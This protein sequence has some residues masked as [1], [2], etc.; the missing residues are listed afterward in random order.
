MRSAA[1]VALFHRPVGDDLLE[2]GRRYHRFWLELAALGLSAAPMS[3]L[4]DDPQAHAAVTQ[5]FNLPTGRELV[6]AFRLGV[7]PPMPAGSKPRLSVG[8]LVV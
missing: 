8:V 4:A 3:V 6:T 5:A 1:A 7:A 2:V